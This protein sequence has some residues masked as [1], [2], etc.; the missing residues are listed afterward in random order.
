MFSEILHGLIIRTQTDHGVDRDR[1]DSELVPCAL[2]VGIIPA[3]GRATRRPAVEPGSVSVLVC[4]ST[5]HFL[6]LSH[7]C[8]SLFFFYFYG[9]VGLFHHAHHYQGKADSAEITPCVEES[10]TEFY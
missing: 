7:F 9:A 6:A 5:P 3:G 4:I 8:L 1:M 2:R 10:E